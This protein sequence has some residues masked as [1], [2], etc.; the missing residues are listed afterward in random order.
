MSQLQST[1]RDL[2][3]VENTERNTEPVVYSLLTSAENERKARHNN[4]IVTKT[5]CVL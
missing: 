1:I 3:S 5:I 2:D 4:I